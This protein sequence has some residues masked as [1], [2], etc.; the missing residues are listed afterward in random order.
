MEDLQ[1]LIRSS[2][3]L[4]KD[5]RKINARNNR[6]YAFGCN[7]FWSMKGVKAEL[8]LGEDMR[9]DKMLTGIRYFNLL[10]SKD[11]ELEFKWFCY[12]YTEIVPTKKGEI[13]IST[14]IF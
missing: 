14:S 5:V 3:V 8:Y 11:S 12:Y 9:G 13:F 4:I 1:K 7:D 10:D 6:L 2:G